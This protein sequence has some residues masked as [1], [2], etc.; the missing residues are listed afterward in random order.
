MSNG[1]RP[2]TAWILI[3]LHF[4]IGFG[5]IISG[6][7]LIVRPDGEL[8]DWTPEILAGTPFNSYLIPGIIL[9]LLIGIFPIF[10]GFGMLKKPVWQGINIIN[11]SRKY[12]WAWAASWAVGVILLV[13][14]I[15]E[16]FMVGY[17]SIL[18]PIV[19]AWGIITL[20]LTLL[21]GLKRYYL[22]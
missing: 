11:P 18:Q 14:I 2:V 3:I 1:S 19:V 9:V 13:W 7:M 12:H 6:A 16:L 22:H 20:I 15:V 21:P 5:G 17:I 4:F 8:M 10:A